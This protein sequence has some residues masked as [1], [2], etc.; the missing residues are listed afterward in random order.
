MISGAPLTHEAMKRFG[1]RFQLEA[2]TG[3]GMT[4][5]IPITIAGDI[6]QV[7]R[8]SVGRPVW[9][10]RLRIVDEA[11]VDLP[12]GQ[13]G[14]IWVRGA[15]VFAGYH[16]PGETD[17]TFSA[18]GWF[19][20]GD[21][22]LL[23]AEGYLYIVDRL[24]DMI[25]RQGYAVYPAEIERVLYSHPAVAE[26]GVIGVPD[27]LTGEEIKAVVARREGADVTAEELI[28]FCRSQLAAYKCPR[29]VEFRDKLPKSP[30]GKV[31]RRLLREE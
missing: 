30:N 5:A 18:D 27:P 8:G 28:E 17:E 14:E 15:Q 10:T 7:P 26:A 19:R 2:F 29:L 25:K 16:P 4:E 21:I 22:G 20:T 31:L 1:Q 6:Q 11:G 12:P 9:G 3:Y 23:D 24:K 13:P